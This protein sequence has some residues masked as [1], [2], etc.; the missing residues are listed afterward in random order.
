MKL[1]Q[2]LLCESETS[3]SLEMCDT[4]P[5]CVQVLAGTHPDVEVVSK[6]ADKA[7][8]PL[9]MFIGDKEHRNREGL[10]HRIALKPMRGR[11]KIAIID[12][13][14]HLNAEGA[15]CL[16]KTLEEP[17]PNSVI[18]LIGTSQQRQLPTIRSRSQIVRFQPLSEESVQR[19]LLDNRLVETAD[20][21]RD[22]ASL[23]GGSVQQALALRDP[24]VRDFRDWFQRNLPDVAG[25]SVDFAKQVMQFVESA[26]KDAPP[27]RV[28]LRTIAMWGVE[29]YRQ[30]MHAAVAA[31]DD[32]WRVERNI[33]LADRCLNVVKHI[34]SNA[35]LTSV[36][37]A[38]IDDL[39]R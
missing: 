25:G 37:E 39:S 18:I 20:E 13:A 21:A 38:W 17:P 35:N 16:L 7:F 1:A 28:R 9:D 14:D 29:H 15:N 2:S 4:C 11:R 27:K 12:D 3:G 23:S 24:E 30:Q 6:P 22:L 8:I 10:C 19:L 32:A 33:D 26:G 36:T 5:S 31:N 34:D